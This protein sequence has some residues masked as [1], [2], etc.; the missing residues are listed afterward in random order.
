MR[1]LFLLPLFYALLI[2]LGMWAGGA[3]PLAPYALTALLG[4]AGAMFS[5]REEVI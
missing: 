2:A 1:W 5:I 3:H 4:A